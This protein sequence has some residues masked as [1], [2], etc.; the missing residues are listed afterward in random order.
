MCDK[1]DMR[2]AAGRDL[3]ETGD[4]ARAAQAA[5]PNGCVRISRGAEMPRV[6][7]AEMAAL[8]GA[9]GVRPTGLPHG[10]PALHGEFTGSIADAIL[11]REPHI[12]T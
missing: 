3:V 10:N 12:N 6:S 4:E 5:M 9:T 7:K 11:A 2:S 1:A 8:A